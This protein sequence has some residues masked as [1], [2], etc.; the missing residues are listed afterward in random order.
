VPGEDHASATPGSQCVT[1]PQ[2]AVPHPGTG[3]L[4]PVDQG[5]RTR[6]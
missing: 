2:T 1:S 4:S 3:S 6:T 5:V